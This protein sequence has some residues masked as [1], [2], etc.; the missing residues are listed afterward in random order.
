MILT[1]THIWPR[2]TRRN[3]LYSST[4]K[5]LLGTFV[6]SSVSVVSFSVYKAEKRMPLLR[7]T[8]WQAYRHIASSYGHSYFFH[9]AVSAALVAMWYYVVIPQPK[10]K[11]TITIGGLNNYQ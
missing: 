11:N 2:D 3:I 5:L 10:P 7:R 4:I 8:R 6:I 1:T 9:A